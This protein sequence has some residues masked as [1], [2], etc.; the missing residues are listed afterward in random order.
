VR[1]ALAR[2]QPKSI[3]DAFI[4]Q[5]VRADFIQLP[6]DRLAE[7]TV[8]GASVHLKVTGPTY[9]RSE[10]VETVRDFPFFSGSPTSN[11]LS[12][13]EAVIEERNATDDPGNELSWKPIDATRALLI[14]N[15]AKPGEWEGDVPFATLAPGLMRLTLKEFE[16]YRTDDAISQDAPRTQIRVA[17]R[18]VYADVFAL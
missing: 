1:L 16:W 5:I 17:R 9:F 15:P 10:V 6:P 11:G 3:K 13:I 14:Q 4:S 12:E 18:L 7:I 2:V 8:G